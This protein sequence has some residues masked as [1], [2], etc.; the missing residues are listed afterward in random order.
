MRGCLTSIR[1]DGPG[2]SSQSIM[3]SLSTLSDSVRLSPNPPMRKMS[4]MEQGV[5]AVGRDADHGTVLG[6]GA[7]DVA[8]RASDMGGL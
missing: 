2:R 5:R 6:S 3:S 1:V 7:S 8:D 4:S